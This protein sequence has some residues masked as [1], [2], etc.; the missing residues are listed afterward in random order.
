MKMYSEII[1]C[2]CSVPEVMHISILD[3]RIYILYIL[4]KYDVEFRWCWISHNIFLLQ[5]FVL[6]YWIAMFPNFF[7]FNF[8][9]AVQGW[10]KIQNREYL[11]WPIVPSLSWFQFY[12][13][14]V[15]FYF[16]KIFLTRERDSHSLI[17]IWIDRSDEWGL[18]VITSIS[19]NLSVDERRN[20]SISFTTLNSKKPDNKNGMQKGSY[21]RVSPVIKH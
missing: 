14:S 13:M 18:L 21:F 15:I 20:L 9:F 19:L 16:Q 2:S 5:K 8:I 7:N 4:F 10:Y 3:H 6:K 12:C 17:Y 1:S 11:S